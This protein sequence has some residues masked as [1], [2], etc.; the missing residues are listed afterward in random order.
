MEESE[1]QE[2]DLLDFSPVKDGAQAAA[3]SAATP[4]ASPIAE[5]ST[6]LQEGQYEKCRDRLTEIWLQ[7]PYDRAVIEL[8]CELLKEIGEVE[9]AKRF[10]NLVAKLKEPTPPYKHHQELFEVGYALVDL[11]QYKLAAMLLS[12]LIKELPEDP[13]INYELGFSLMCLKQFGKAVT[14]FEKFKNARDDFDVVLN[15]CVCYTLLR[16]EEA[17]AHT[18]NSLKPLA[19]SEEEKL[20]FS[21]RQTVLKRLS[22]LSHKKILNERDWFF[23]LYGSI[24]LRPGK[25]LPEGKL[26]LKHVASTLVILNGLLSGLAVQEE[27]IEYYSL[28]SKPMASVFSELCEL[29][30]DSYRGPDRP[31]KCLLMM[32][33]T[34]DILG[35]HQV[36]INNNEQRGLFAL[37]ISPTEPLPVIPDI[38][39]YTANDILMPWE[40]RE[41][42]PREL[43]AQMKALLE[44]AQNLEADPDLL[45][46]TQDA[47][48]YYLDKLDLLVFAN[49]PGFANRPEYT[50]ELPAL[51]KDPEK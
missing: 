34:T 25:S 15:L 46:E 38:I 12:E 10:A 40:G 17:A 45:R 14:H 49:S 35:P 27:G 32:S 37:A 24:L 21:H 3:V 8:Y 19:E 5:A 41:H 13:L 9:S 48:D 1:N 28:R 51:E 50:A 4:S 18:L 39:G 36:F 6:L 20:E 47:L 33:W 44:K 29:P 31:D 26:E 7:A 16:N 23:I 42:S 11:R 30:V 22:R 43:E 2:Q